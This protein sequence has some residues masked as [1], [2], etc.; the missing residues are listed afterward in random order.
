MADTVSM[1]GELVNVSTIS[2][3]VVERD[4]SGGAKK[5]GYRTIKGQYTWERKVYRK[6]KGMFYDGSPPHF[7]VVVSGGRECR[8]KVT[9]S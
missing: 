5:S 9:L 6:D 7:D 4:T 2:L 8:S 1:A 3:K